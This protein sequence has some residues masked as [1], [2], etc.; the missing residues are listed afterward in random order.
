MTFCLRPHGWESRGLR[1]PQPCGFPL[2]VGEDAAAG[3]AVERI[4]P[5]R[6]D[7]EAAGAQ[8]DVGRCPLT[9]TDPGTFVPVLA[10]A[11]IEPA[12][13]GEDVGFG[14]GELMTTHNGN[15][16]SQTRRSST[17]WSR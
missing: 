3:T 12:S 1:F 9:R 11:A 10:A 17:G 16:I 6:L 15:P 7:G 2:R 4:A 5:Q 13:V 14:L 8:A